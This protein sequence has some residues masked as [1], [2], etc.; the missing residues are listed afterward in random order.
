V[1][2]VLAKPETLVSEGQAVLRGENPALATEV[3]SLQA[4]VEQLKVRLNAELFEQ[5]VQAAVTREA[6]E[7]QR[8]ALAR[9]EERLQ[10]LLVEARTAG[11]LVLPRAADLPGRFLRQGELIGYVLS[12]APR[13]VRVV[14]M[15]DDIELVRNRLRHVEVKITD[16]LADTFFVRLVRE[17]PGAV[18]QLPTRALSIEGGGR[19]ATDPRDPEGVKAL[20]RL[21]QFDLELPA[22]VGTVALGTR[23]FVRFAHDPEPLTLQAYRRIRQLFLTHFHV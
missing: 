22:E 6:L 18:D 17:V 15:Q 9:A 7:R 2:H 20:Q 1:Q 11:R 3:K 8:S 12:G 16:R 10:D 14:V 13:T 23:V 5:R 4:R 19:H 21:F